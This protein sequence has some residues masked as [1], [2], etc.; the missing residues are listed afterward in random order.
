MKCRV[1]AITQ[2]HLRAIGS[3]ISP[4]DDV[5]AFFLAVV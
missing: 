4:R 3:T 2:R 1:M 5:V